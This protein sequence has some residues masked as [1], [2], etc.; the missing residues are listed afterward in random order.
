MSYFC[1]YKFNAKN[2]TLTLH[3]CCLFGKCI[4]LQAIQN[5]TVNSFLYAHRGENKIPYI[6][7]N[8]IENILH[9][10]NYILKIKKT[11]GIAVCLKTTS[12]I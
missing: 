1:P 12:A 10:C 3:K 8:S 9:L 5:T 2:L 11:L 7:A 4:N 6:F